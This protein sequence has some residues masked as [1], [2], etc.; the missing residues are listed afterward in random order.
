MDTRKQ[1]LR[2]LAWSVIGALA[3]LVSGLLVPPI[4]IRK[5]GSSQYG[6]WA[7]TLSLVEYFWLI[8]FGLRPAT[9]KLSAEYRALGRLDDLQRIL[10]T[11]LLYSG[12]AGLLVLAGVWANTARIASLFQIDTPEF[13]VLIRVIGISWALGLSVNILAATLEGY[14]RFDLTN[15]IA[16]L[17]AAVRSASTIAV[18]T[19]G[20]GLREMSIALLASQM[21]Y[22]ALIVVCFRAEC[23]SIALMP[24]TPGRAQ[25]RILW[26]LGRQTFS[27]LISGRLI[28][29]SIP[30]LIA[31]FL[32][33]RHVAYYTVCLRI[34][35]YT[36]ESIGR[37][38]VATGPR[39]MDWMA[40]G[41]TSRV[42]HLAHYGNRYCL[43]LW[44]PIACLVAVF[45]EHACRLW[46]NDEVARHAGAILPLLVV[47]HTLWV[48]QF[49]SSAIL[50]GIGRY[51][52]YSTSLLLESFAIIGGFAAVLPHFGLVGA[53]AVSSAFYILNR[54][55]NL[56]RIFCKEFKL[57]PGPFLLSIY[58]RPMLLCAASLLLLAAASQYVTVNTWFRLIGLSSAYGVL[59]G[60]AAF[61]WI[62]EPEHQELVF[63]RTRLLRARWLPGQASTL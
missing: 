24:F 2:N 15:K 49:I 51:E 5:L 53:A 33:T 60:A 39:A 27:A 10:H 56:A 50:M 3:L 20:Y 35:D 26:Q 42:I 37:I 4:L 8:D 18:V 11:A 6:I 23:P 57:A 19:L 17:A 54:C 28:Q 7:L 13:P 12:A 25:A 16:I 63:E 34:L 59:Y 36:G 41:H 43:A 55:L 21:L 45:G 22:Y 48:G 14:Q 32:S 46:I 40:R 61:W 31:F 9:V 29:S 47:G 52:A 44:V 38:G 62:V 30:A 1:Y 58:L